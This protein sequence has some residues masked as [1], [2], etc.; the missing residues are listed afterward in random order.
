MFGSAVY[1][2]L[3]IYLVTQAHVSL[4]LC[5]NRPLMHVLLHAVTDCIPR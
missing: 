5:P 1:C 3:Q 4:A 2:G